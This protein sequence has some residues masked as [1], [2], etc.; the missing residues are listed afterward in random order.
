M[1]G[2]SRQYL[3]F[4]IAGEWFALP[5]SSILR[6]E[7]CPELTPV[8]GAPPALPG[9][10]A[11]QGQL[12]AA[13]EPR[14]VLGMPAAEDSPAFMVIARQGELTAGLIVDWVEAVVMVSADEIEPPAGPAAE[15]SDGYAQAHGIQASLLRLAAVLSSATGE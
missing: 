8:P 13:L 15:F 1:G 2:G 4:R 3:T 7:P 10:F 11:S 6:V 5:V 14:A 9:V 12:V